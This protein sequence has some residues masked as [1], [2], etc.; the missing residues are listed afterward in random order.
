MRIAHL[1]PYFFP[2]SVGGTEQYVLRLSRALQGNGDEVCVLVPAILGRNHVD[3]DY[4]GVPVHR[5]PVE[6]EEGRHGLRP[7][8]MY[9][10]W[11]AIIN[12]LKHWQPDVVHSHFIGLIFRAEE[13][14]QAKELGIAVLATLHLPNL[15]YGCPKGTM[16]TSDGRICDGKV[17]PQRCTNCILSNR[18]LSPF[19]AK[20]LSRIPTALGGVLDS[21]PGRLGTALGMTA[22]IRI[23]QRM[24]EAWIEHIDKVVLVSQWSRRVLMLNGAPSGKL[25]TISTGVEVP[26][27]EAR[28]PK[29]KEERPPVKIGYIGR[30]DPVKGVDILVQAM[31]HLPNNENLLLDIYGT[32]SH[33]YTN[34][35]R[36]MVEGDRRIRLLGLLPEEQ[37]YSKRAEM[38]LICVPSRCLETF[39]LVV[40]EAQ[41][42]EVPVI[43]SDS[44]GIAEQ[45]RDGLNGRLFPI[46][47]TRALADILLEV[48][49]HP[50]LI[51]RWRKEAKPPRTSTQMAEEYRALY[52]TIIRKQS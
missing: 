12:F 22:R 19:L 17:E 4:R 30:L 35:L 28:S 14:V 46:G 41:A 1:V 31:R 39:S 8:G 42:M 33:Q 10:G 44:G 3:G 32:G 7:I 2:D 23:M 34:N 27:E 48:E 36:S 21:L 47:D 52:E 6:I 49:A 40:A 38:D 16:V 9:D 11:Q 37:V 18:Q 15:G 51:D 24:Q 13:V 25:V 5:F 29:R 45:I 26:A 50:E 43:G 20:P